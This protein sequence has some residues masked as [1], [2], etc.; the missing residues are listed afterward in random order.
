[1][2]G[3]RQTMAVI[4]TFICLFLARHPP[5]GQ[6]QTNKG[7]YHCH[8]L[9]SSR[10]RLL[11]FLE[12]RCKTQ[13]L[14]SVGWKVGPTLSGQVEKKNTL[15]VSL[16]CCINWVNPEKMAELVPQAELAYSTVIVERKLKHYVAVSIP[17]S[18][19]HLNLPGRQRYNFARIQVVSMEGGRGGAK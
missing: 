11:N 9:S 2:T 5:L 18:H 10:H 12:R 17:L 16:C 7:C 3:A 1:M 19:L 8:R 15:Y 13:R 14:Q 4:T 6:K